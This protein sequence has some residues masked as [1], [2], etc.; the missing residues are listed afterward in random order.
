MPIRPHLDGQ[1]FDSETIRVMGL[2]FEMALVALRLADRGDLANEVLARRIMDLAKAGERDPERLC[3]GVSRASAASM[4]DAPEKNSRSAI[5]H[6]ASTY[7]QVRQMIVPARDAMGAAR[8]APPE[9]VAGNV[10]WEEKLSAPTRERAQGEASCVNWQA[11]LSS[12]SPSSDRVRAPRPARGAPSTI[13][14]HTIAA[15]TATR[16]ATPPSMGTADGADKTFSS[17]P[18]GIADRARRVRPPAI[19]ALW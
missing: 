7:R 11:A 17:H 16:S 6:P 13:H 8:P 9:R 3:E 19:D 12:P 14:R 4:T 2:A 18:A 5:K 1:K 10:S 15:S